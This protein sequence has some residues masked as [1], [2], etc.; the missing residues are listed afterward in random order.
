MPGVIEAAGRYIAEQSSRIFQRILP[1][2]IPVL[3]AVGGLAGAMVSSFFVRGG[4]IAIL[5]LAAAILVAVVVWRFRLAQNRRIRCSESDRLS[6]RS[7]EKV[8]RVVAPR[9]DQQVQEGIIAFHDF[10]T[11][12]GCFDHW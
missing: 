8:E 5:L 1:K 11:A 12:R 6:C 3:V 9:L 7:A 4:L 2:K 10:N